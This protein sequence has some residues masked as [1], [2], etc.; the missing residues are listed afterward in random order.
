[1][2][3]A[4]LTI[5]A[6]LALATGSAVAADPG[7][8]KPRGAVPDPDAPAG[9]QW[10]W[11]PEER[12]VDQRWLPFEE[13]LLMAELGVD[14]AE[15]IELL[16]EAR[17]LA[18]TARDQGLPTTLLMDRLLAWSDARGPQQRELRRRTYKTLTQPHLGQHM[19][20]HE[21]HNSSIQRAAPSIFGMTPERYVAEISTEL[22]CP[23]D[24]GRRHGRTKLHV[25]EQ[26]LAA[27]RASARRGVRRGW[28]PPGQ[29]ERFAHHQ[30]IAVADW[31]TS[32][33]H[34]VPIALLR[35]SAG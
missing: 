34:G 32:N 18:E 33:V 9:A 23:I 24:V 4:L 3:L 6:L 11:L 14:Y 15:L 13:D 10:Y 17:P 5:L 22:V 26:T 21:F 16:R 35:G 27:L 7:P 20:T 12:W 1:M 19:F 25:R 31:L 29:G 8:Q 28:M 30:R 2:R